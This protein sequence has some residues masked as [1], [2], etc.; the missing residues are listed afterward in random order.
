[1]KRDSSYCAAAVSPHA[2]E[3]LEQVE[4]S[5]VLLHVL[6]AVAS[7]GNVQRYGS[8]VLTEVSRELLLAV[9]GNRDSHHRALLI[10]RHDA[11][12]LEAHDRLYQR[13]DVARSDIVA[14]I[15]R[16]VA[17]AAEL[18]GHGAS[19]VDKLGR[20]HNAVGADC[21]HII[22]LNRALHVDKNM[23]E[24]IHKRLERV[25][26]VRQLVDLSQ[27][28]YG[29][30]RR[31]IDKSLLSAFFGRGFSFNIVIHGFS[32]SFCSWAARTAS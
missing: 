13:T 12:A 6:V 32:L 10:N 17:A 2:H 27:V 31:F 30:R 19:C 15:K 8:A 18:Y 22:W 29:N 14:D 20:N 26:L 4:L 7:R 9:A 23:P 25:G 5:D 28:L 16:G 1:M 24:D 3:S 11:D 21:R